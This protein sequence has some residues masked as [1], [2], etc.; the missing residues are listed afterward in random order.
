MITSDSVKAPSNFLN[1]SRFIRFSSTSAYNYN[2]QN[3]K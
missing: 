3:F 1:G 2:N